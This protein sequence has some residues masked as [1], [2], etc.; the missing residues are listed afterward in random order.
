MDFNLDPSKG[1]N[2]SKYKFKIST[3]NNIADRDRGIQ[4]DRYE[5]TYF[6]TPLI[7]YNK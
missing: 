5:N 4:G 1:E 7:T 2:N 6:M 3:D